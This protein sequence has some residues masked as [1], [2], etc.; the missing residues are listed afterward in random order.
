MLVRASDETDHYCNKPMG[1]MC[2][3]LSNFQYIYIYT[4]TDL[5]GMVLQL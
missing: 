2:S 3:A 5:S 4:A 1:V